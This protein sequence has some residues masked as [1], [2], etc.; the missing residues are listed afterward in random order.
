MNGSSIKTRFLVTLGANLVRGIV[1]LMIAVL[2]ARM[3]GAD[4]YGRIAFLLATFQTIRQLTD[5]A[6]S[7]AFYTFLSQKSRSIRF[8][9][10]YWGFLVAKYLLS[11]GLIMWLM[12][13]SW[14][15][16]VWRGEPRDLVVFAMTA[17]FMQFDGGQTAMQMLEAQRR[18]A[19][20][21]GLFSLFL[22]LQLLSIYLLYVT[23][24]LSIRNYVLAS[25]AV[26]VTA[27]I[28]AVSGYRTAAVVDETSSARSVYRQYLLYCVP[29]VPLTALTFLNDFLDRWFLQAWAGSTEQAYF[30]ISQQVAAATLL[31]TASLIRVLWKEMA[32]AI[33]ENR[34]DTAMHLYSRSKKGLFF[35]SAC[36]AGVLGPWAREVLSLTFG[37]GYAGAVPAFAVMVFAAV[38]QTLGQIEGTLLL[39]SGKTK[40]GFWF[41]FL[42]SPFAVALSFFILSAG[43]GGE[44]LLLP[45]ARLG[46]LGLAIKLIVIQMITVNVLGYLLCRQMNWRFEWAYQVKTLILTGAVGFG[47]KG[48]FGTDET[49]TIH[50]LALGVVLYVIVIV[51][52]LVAFPKFFEIDLDLK[53]RTR[54]SS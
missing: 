15:N 1:T 11:V 54:R 31:I 43:S 6:I 47:V 20:A 35:L 16:Y 28:V 49:G 14:I 39:A 5:P 10:A 48:L 25:A 44:T 29:M 23:E 9:G 2:L 3:L 46:A 26:W 36:I 42:I 41:N 19:L 17:V 8:V 18:T 7:S 33:H 38:Y 40:T 22:V 12:P 37:E 34:N 53:G 52:V 51:A 21:Q 32:Q 50:F 45:G 4:G 24:L 30:S 27:T 13:D